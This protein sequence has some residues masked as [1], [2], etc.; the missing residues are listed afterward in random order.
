M[1][2]WID[3]VGGGAAAAGLGSRFGFTGVGVFGGAVVGVAI[4]VD[5]GA[6]VSVGADVLVLLVLLLWVVFRDSKTAT[7]QDSNKMVRQDRNTPRK[8]Q[9]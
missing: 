2:G 5:L 8:Q 7:R 1:A 9:N 4:G 6:D 3:G